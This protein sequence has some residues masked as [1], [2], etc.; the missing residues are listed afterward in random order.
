[1][2]GVRDLGLSTFAKLRAVTEVLF[3]RPISGRFPRQHCSTGR[4]GTSEW[5]INVQ[6]IN[7]QHSTTQIQNGH[8][9]ELEGECW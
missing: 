2:C 7:I 4:K 6:S 9:L 8:Q 5:S 3:A 1:M